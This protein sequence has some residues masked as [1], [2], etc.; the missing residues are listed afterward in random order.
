MIQA[1]ELNPDAS[2]R[3]AVRQARSEA[4]NDI[5]ESES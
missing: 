1:H 4:R 3:S 2:S 5:K